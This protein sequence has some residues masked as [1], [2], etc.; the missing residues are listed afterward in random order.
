[1]VVN[2]P[3]DPAI[4]INKEKPSE[5]LII[6]TDKPIGGGLYAFDL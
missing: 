5:S 6:G 2:D 1:M 3:D 4:W